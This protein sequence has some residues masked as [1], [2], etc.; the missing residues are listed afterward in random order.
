[1]K[2]EA[3]QA[4]QNN[5]HD[6]HSRSRRSSVGGGVQARNYSGNRKWTPGTIIQQTGP[7]SARI[8]LENGDIVRRH[9]DKLLALESQPIEG[10]VP[11]SF[12]SELPFGNNARSASPQRSTTTVTQ[13]G[14]G[15]GCG[16]M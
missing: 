16:A 8:K 10:L 14:M 9:Q 12:E 5:Q 13:I 7:I 2:V 4:R 6:Q 11:P 15:R 1:M 3:V